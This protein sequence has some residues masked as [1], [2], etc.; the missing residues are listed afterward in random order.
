[1]V[2]MVDTSLREQALLIAMR[3]VELSDPEPCDVIDEH[4]FG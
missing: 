2:R 4:M 1:M 3:I